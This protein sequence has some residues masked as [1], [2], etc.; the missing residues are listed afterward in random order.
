MLNPGAIQPLQDSHRKRE[1]PAKSFR[2]QYF[3]VEN[4]G[5]KQNEDPELRD[6]R[7]SGAVTHDVD[8]STKTQASPSRN[9]PLKIN[10]ED[11]RVNN[12]NSLTDAEDHLARKSEVCMFFFTADLDASGGICYDCSIKKENRA[13]PRRHPT[14]PRWSQEKHNTQ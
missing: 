5:A 4:L 10:A 8:L 13:E 9:M 6:H 7:L 1:R 2:V 3:S 14:T 12:S 11:G